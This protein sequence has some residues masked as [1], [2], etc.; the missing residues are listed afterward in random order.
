M[1]SE[2]SNYIKFF[3]KN[4]EKTILEKLKEITGDNNLTLENTIFNEFGRSINVGDEI[5]EYINAMGDDLLADIDN[6]ENNLDE[7][8]FDYKLNENVYSQNLNLFN[9]KKEEI[10]KL[11]KEIDCVEDRLIKKV[12][13]LDISLKKQ[14]INIIIDKLNYFKEKIK[15]IV[16]KESGLK[17]TN[18]MKFEIIKSSTVSSKVLN[19]LSKDTDIGILRKIAKHNNA[20]KHTLEY[21]AS[22]TDDFKVLEN[23]L[24]NEN[25]PTKVVNKLL[26]NNDRDIF[27]KALKHNN[28]SE[29]LLEK[30]SKTD[31]IEIVFSILKNKSCSLKV[32]ENIVIKNANNKEILKNVFNH[33][34]CLNDLKDLIKDIANKEKK[35][36][37]K[38]KINQKQEIINQNKET[39]NLNISN[40]QVKK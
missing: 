35:L 2:E 11:T 5:N 4:L 39:K 20:E 18:E 24:N 27:L 17:L 37:L 6:L 33:K 10:N 38:D 32:L 23:L 13:K 34:N 15:N 12:N 7:W 36:S 14:F 1:D 19:T 9:S 21:I 31:D 22:K 40:S 26:K 30:Y 28:I 8:F 16:S 29:N 3:K 25:T